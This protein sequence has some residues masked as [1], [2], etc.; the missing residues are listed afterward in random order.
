MTS[1]TRK[2]PGSVFRLSAGLALMLMAATASAVGTRTF[3]LDQGDD[4]KGGDLKGTAVD[5]AGK[6]R[7]GLNLGTT[8]VSDATTIWSVLPEKD[9]SFLLGTGNEGK[10]LRVKNGK[11]STVAETKALAITSLAEAWGGSVAMGT[12]PDG[13]V[14]KYERGKVSDL[15]TIK[16]VEHVWSV[17][18]DKKT[19]SL[20]AA[21]GPEGKL[22]RI[23]QGG[24]AQV[25]FDAA[26]QHLMSVAVAPDGTVYAGASDK[27]KLYKITGPGRGSVLYDFGRTEVR[28]IAVSAKGE[29]FAIA[30]EIQ[31]G[32]FA[33]TRRNRATPDAAGPTPKPPKTRGKG[34][35]VKFETDGTPDVLLDDKTEHFTSLALGDDGRPYV[36]TGAEARV[37]TVDDAH[38]SVLVADTDERMI[39][40]LGMSGKHRFVASSDPAVLHEVRGVGGT[41]SVW[42]SKVFDAG[43][44]AK[45]GR[46]SWVSTGTLELS[47]R[48]GNTKDPDDT[49]S[50]W[51]K[52]MTAAGMIKSPAARYFQV[53]AR[54]SRD[55]D[56]VLS[57]VTIPFVT[58]NLRAVV[59]SVDITKKK[60]TEKGGDIPQSGAPIDGG[61]NTKVSLSWKVDNPD[62]DKLRYKLEYR[63][64]GTTKWYDM[65]KPTEKVTSETYS[66]DTADM[67]EGEYRI[68]VT[69]SDDIS[70]PPGRA[71]SHE[72]ESGV[73]L[74]DNT[75]PRVEGLKATGRRI[76]GRAIDGVGPI[77]R[78]EVSIVGTDDWYPFDP[79]DGIFDEQSEDFEADVSSFSPSGPVLAAVRVYDAANNFVVRNVAL[80]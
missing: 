5:S 15:V 80:K 59:T 37:Y 45:W 29:V 79:K 4:F 73:I 11:V 66:W 47:T 68:R 64:V 50:P 36:G 58:D 27:A 71:R 8:S 9:G 70:N 16:G 75:P 61:T 13:K 42:T 62:K 25:Y 41:D 69:A 76:R 67:P 33:P 44:R 39:G 6:V 54:W 20:F 23:D 53:R 65:L 31:S 72:L 32:A 40:A 1:D 35:L 63:L 48:T 21:T 10:L 17:A 52:P 55:K 46:M 14:M 30:N 28:A 38:N 78:I 60:K 49:W 43:I 51:S 77:Q 7:A 24:T 12:L 2:L 34:T 18:F 57:E 22:Y 3:E 19:N 56:A 74:V 26:E